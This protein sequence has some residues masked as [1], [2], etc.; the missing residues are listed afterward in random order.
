[1]TPE[2]ADGLRALSKHPRA[3]FFTRRV[4]QRW[5]RGEISIDKVVQLLQPT[6][7]TRLVGA[8]RYPV[9]FEVTLEIDPELLDD[10]ATVGIVG[11][12]LVH[13]GGSF[14]HWTPDTHR[15]PAVARFRFSTADERDRFVA[16]ALEIPGVSL[17]TLQ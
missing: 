15:H 6:D 8:W 3:S 4:L 12:R 1:M 17:A 9:T 16:A 13:L 7:G 11:L 5:T 2:Q 14:V 10:D